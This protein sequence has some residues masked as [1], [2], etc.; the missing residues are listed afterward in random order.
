MSQNYPQGN[1]GQSPHPGKLSGSMVGNHVWL[2]LASSSS[3]C[4]SSA[5]AHLSIVHSYPLLSML[6]AAIFMQRTRFPIKVK[7]FRHFGDFKANPTPK[8][9]E[10]LI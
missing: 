1:V 6:P 7:R 3:S 9:L 10:F 5:A 4:I 8:A 2:L